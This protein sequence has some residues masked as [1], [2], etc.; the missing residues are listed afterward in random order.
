MISAASEP[1]AVVQPAPVT[2]GPRGPL[3]WSDEFDGPGLDPARWSISRDCSGGGNHERQC[4]SDDPNNIEVANGLLRL[5]ARARIAAGPSLEPSF[6]SGRIETRGK[7]SFRYGR[8]EIRARLP[9]GQGLWPAIWMLPEHD[10]YGPYPRSGE[11]DIAEAVNLGVACEACEDRLHGAIHQGPDPAA[12]TAV[13]G[14]TPLPAAGD[15]HVFALD[16]GQDR[17]TW[18]LDGRPYHTAHGGLPFDQRF[19]LILNL[20]V[21]GPWAE[22]SARGGVDGQAFPAELLIDWIRVYAPPD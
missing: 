17:L 5:T 2:P 14:S 10:N 7:A 21:G 18:L 11:I 19:H 8:I 1:P 3:I 15:F 4:Y 9:A 20:A 13:A 22:N 6:T 12:N 16:W